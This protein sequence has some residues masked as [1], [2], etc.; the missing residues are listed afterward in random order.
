MK[1]IVTLLFCF[2]ETCYKIL[3]W[4]QFGEFIRVFFDN[5]DVAVEVVKLMNIGIYYVSKESIYIIDIPLESKLKYSIKEQV[6]TISCR[7]I[8]ESQKWKKF[9]FDWNCIPEQHNYIARN[10]D[11]IWISYVNLPEYDKER[12]KWVYSHGG[13]RE[14]SEKNSPVIENSFTVPHARDLLFKR[15]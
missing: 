12:E 4:E 3:K 10:E 11:G 7:D 15:I 2:E 6:T 9:S 8:H 13:F 1:T 5:S 14:I